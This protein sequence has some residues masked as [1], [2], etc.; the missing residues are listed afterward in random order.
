MN[1]GKSPGRKAGDAR[2]RRANE[3]VNTKPQ[4]L[5]RLIL[6]GKV[7]AVVVAVLFVSLKL[8]FWFLP[9]LWMGKEK[10]RLD[11]KHLGDV[12]MEMHRARELPQRVRNAKGR[13]LY[14][15]AVQEGVWPPELHWLVVSLNGPDSPVGSRPHNAAMPIGKNN[16]S[17]T[18]PYGRD[19]AQ[20]W[21]RKGA[22]RR[23]VITFNGRNWNNY[24]EEGV[25]VFWSDAD[26]A[27]WLT[28]EEAER[29]WGITWDEWSN[30]SEKLLGKKAPF[31]FTHE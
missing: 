23:V 18:G 16:C 2:Q 26:R 28:F 17:Y 20:L 9:G 3:D 29:D 4:W 7:L 1:S 22:D 13:E 5:R 30:P 15:A 19:I 14:E 25:I 6:T 10:V 27:S 31:E 8:L 12:V 24:P 21:G 11:E